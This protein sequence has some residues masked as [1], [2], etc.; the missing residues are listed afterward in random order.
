MK[1]DAIDQHPAT[2]AAPIPPSD[3][4]PEAHYHPRQASH[5]SR[6]FWMLIISLVVVVVAIGLAIWIHSRVTAAAA[7]LAA[8]KG[9]PPIPV[10]VATAH[11]GDVPI[12]LAALG[13]V[14]PF[15]T[16][17][18]H[19]RV[20]GQLDKVAFKEGQLVKAGDL[21]AQIDPRPFQAAVEQAQGQLVK[22]QALLEN[23]RLD[24]KRYQTAADGTFTQQQIDTQQ[25][26]VDQDVGTVQSDQGNL[27]NA[28]VQLDY[29]QITSPLTGRI[30]LRLVDPG[31][32]VQTTDAT[33]LAVI[34]QLQPIAVIFPISDVDIPRVMD[35]SA[36]APHLEADAYSND[37]TTRLGRGRLIAADSQIDP[38]TA[39]L[40]LK[41]SF[42][43]KNNA[44]Y[45]NQFV[46]VQLLVSTL[47]GAVVVPPAAVQRGPDNGTFVYIVKAD[48]TVD[49]DNVTLGALQGNSQAITSGL[50][51]GDIV[52]ID[53][54]DKLQPGSKVVK[55]QAATQP[56]DATG[57][58][59]RAS[60]HHHHDASTQPSDDAATRLDQ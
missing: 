2:R 27:D 25:A 34:T 28:K 29:C 6:G 4:L 44:L 21:L 38:T 56:S 10:V 7:K 36:T 3:P 8:S 9:L 50:S 39:T 13:T 37:L 59:T 52:V 42:D 49:V 41:A 57:A 58:T 43:N 30:G 55:R 35:G 46:N 14:T 22:D 45:P 17:T 33:G 54:V 19:T 5:V 40:K 48:D 12:Y 51:P 18:I 32:I 23:A 1:Q 53:G 16:V 20:N 47:Q 11:T 60:H 24:L 31:N 26:L 15:N